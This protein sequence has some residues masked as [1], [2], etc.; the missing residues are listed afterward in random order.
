MGI[1]MTVI[2]IGGGF[3]GSTRRRD[4]FMQVCDTLRSALDEHF[5]SSGGTHILAEPGQFIV[6]S[7]Y[8]LAVKVVAKRT[9]QTSVD[10]KLRLYHDVYINDSRENSIPREVEVYEG[11]CINYQPLS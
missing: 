2:D 7:S 3:P 4:S 10:G 8:T 9:R 5:P 11:L 6:T 1:N